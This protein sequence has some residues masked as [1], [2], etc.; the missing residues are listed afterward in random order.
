MA[1]QRKKKSPYQRIVDAAKKGVGVRLSF[2]E[3]HEMSRDTAI[4][5]LAEND[6]HKSDYG[7][8]Q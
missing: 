6:D 5:D 4:C 8:G 2:E 1:D 7:T 3:C